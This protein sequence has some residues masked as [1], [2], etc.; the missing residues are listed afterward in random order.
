MA[1]KREGMIWLREVKNLIRGVFEA[2]VPRNSDTPNLG[3]IPRILD[4]YDFFYRVCN[5]APCFDYIR[6]TVLK[7][8][9]RYAKGD[10][11]LSQAQVALMLQMEAERDIRTMGKRFLTFSGKVMEDWIDS[12]ERTGR[13]G[14]VSD[15]DSYDILKYLLF[16]DLFAYGIKRNCKLRWIDT[17]SLSDGQLDRLDT[18][19]FWQYIGFDKAAAYVSGASLEEQDARYVSLFTRLAA[20]NDLHPFFKE[21]LAMDLARYQ[22]A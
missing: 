15:S 19:T 12:L 4:A 1:I 8:A 3:D 10:K 7:T 14:R 11:N 16:S 5:G 18:K 13:I 2:P 17:Y 21:G 20:R 22:T 6:E 9:N